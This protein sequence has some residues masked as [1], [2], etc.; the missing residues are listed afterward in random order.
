MNKANEKVFEMCYFRENLPKDI[1]TVNK[2]KEEVKSY[3]IQI[4]SRYN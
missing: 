4:D 2:A 3:G 1:N